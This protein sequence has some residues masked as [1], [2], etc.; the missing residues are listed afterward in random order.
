MKCVYKDWDNEVRYYKV[1]KDSI[2]EMDENNKPF[3]HDGCCRD[4]SKVDDNCPCESEYYDA[5]Q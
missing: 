1:T 3:I 2:Y 5:Y 4:Q